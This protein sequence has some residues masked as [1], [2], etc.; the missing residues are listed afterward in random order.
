LT[1]A[2][3]D[4]LAGL[5]SWQETSQPRNAGNQNVHNIYWNFIETLQRVF[6]QGHYVSYH[7]KVKNNGNNR[8]AR[9]NVEHIFGDAFEHSPPP[10]VSSKISAGEFR[11]NWGD[12]TPDRW[13]RTMKQFDVTS[14]VHGG[15]KR[16]CATASAAWRYS[17]HPAR[18][19]AINMI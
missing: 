7:R 19:I 3:V 12:S 9:D 8:K 13:H 15:G 17:P 14:A 2:A 5:L 16:R 1:K 11:A 4:P 6:W 18:L 10:G